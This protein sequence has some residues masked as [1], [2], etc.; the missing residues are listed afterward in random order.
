MSANNAEEMD[1]KSDA[2]RCFESELPQILDTSELHLEK[3]L[4]TI[5]NYLRDNPPTGFRK[6]LLAWQ[7]RFYLEHGKYADAAQV[8][9]AA[10]SLCTSDELKNANVKLDLADALE[11]T[12]N[13]QR[14]YETLSAGTEMLKTPPLKAKVMARAAELRRRLP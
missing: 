9:E 10:D 5:D 12:G 8:L 4:A 14:A 3:A 1:D 6:S 2:E 13:L 11:K 7:G